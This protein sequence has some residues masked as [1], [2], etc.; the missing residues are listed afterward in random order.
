MWFPAP[1][2]QQVTLAVHRVRHDFGE[3]DRALL[4]VLRT[5][6]AQ[7]YRNAESVHL[8]RTSAGTAGHGVIRIGP[9][10][11]AN[12]DARA[13]MLLAKFFDRRPSEGSLP[14]DLAQWVRQHELSHRIE[15]T[16]AAPEPFR[17]ECEGATMTAR[18]FAGPTQR[19]L[20]LEETSTT[21]DWR[22][23]KTL[24]LTRR[25]TEV[26][27]WI[28]EGKTNEEI[29]TILGMS[30]RTV[31]KHLERTFPKLGVE[32]R[33]AAAARALKVLRNGHRGD[34]KTV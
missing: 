19:L 11:R 33:T 32:N 27:R 17:I 1:A 31:A 23:L 20:L 22:G 34:H 6:L 4:N 8:L 24:S 21:P 3:R 29:G 30:R 9:S 7:A 25:E 12:I 28:A 10:G 18:L 14:Q 15:G 13:G 2:P 16:S 26:V 5:H